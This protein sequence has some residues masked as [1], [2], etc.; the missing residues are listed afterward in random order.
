MLSNKRSAVVEFGVKPLGAT[1]TTQ[2]TTESTP[3]NLV[4]TEP[5]KTWPS[6]NKVLFYSQAPNGVWD[7]LHED[8]CEEASLLMVHYWLTGQKPSIG[9]HENN[10]QNMVR[11]EQDHHYSESI[12][13]QQIV[14]V[15][16][17]YLSIDLLESKIN[18]VNDLETILTSGRPVLIPAD[19][20]ALHNPHFKNGGPEYHM[21]VVVGYD[22]NNFIVMDPGTKFG[23]NYKYDKTVL[24]GAIAAWQGSDTLP[25]RSVFTLQN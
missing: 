11:W 13:N 1:V 25:D 2:E 12:N 17:Q 14:A 3:H 16:K 20:K 23:K 21:L 8:A 19:G 10:I 15:A 5:I 6:P 22:T 9:E 4:A 18:K 7:A 24:L